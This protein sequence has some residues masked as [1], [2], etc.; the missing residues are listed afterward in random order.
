MTSASISQPIGPSVYTTSANRLTDSGLAL[1]G[2]RSRPRVRRSSLA[3][4]GLASSP[5][6]KSPARTTPPER[7]FANVSVAGSS[8]PDSRDVA[9]PPPASATIPTSSVVV[10]ASVTTVATPAAQRDPVPAEQPHEP[11]EERPPSTISAAIRA[12]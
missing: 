6:E 8:A 10:S 5:P 1:V 11:A 4:G 2:R 3:A 9:P 7:G 12:C